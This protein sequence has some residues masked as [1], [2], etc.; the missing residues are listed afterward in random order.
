MLLSGGRIGTCQSR[1]DL[2]MTDNC[3]EIKPV[4]ASI[5]LK[6]SPIALGIA[7]QFLDGKSPREQAKRI[8]RAALILNQVASDMEAGQ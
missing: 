4:V 2:P 1:E 7:T 6:I 8:R 3:V 5:T